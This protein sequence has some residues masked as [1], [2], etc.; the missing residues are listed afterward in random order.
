MNGIQQLGNH[1][2]VRLIGE[3]AQRF[4]SGATGERVRNRV[5]RRWVKRLQTTPQQKWGVT[6]AEGGPTAVL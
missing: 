4:N 5:R 2:K 1:E 3:R 6:K